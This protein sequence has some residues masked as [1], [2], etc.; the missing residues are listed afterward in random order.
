MFRKYC[1]LLQTTR[2]NLTF[3]FNSAINLSSEVW[4]SERNQ[5][6]EYIPHSDRW[7]ACDGVPMLTMWNYPLRKKAPLNAVQLVTLSR[8]RN[9]LN[10]IL[11]TFGRR[12]RTAP[13]QVTKSHV[14]KM[15]FFVGLSERKCKKMQVFSDTVTHTENKVISLYTRKAAVSDNLLTWLLYECS[16]RQSERRRLLLLSEVTP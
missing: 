9:S 15:L 5:A 1:L 2:Q 10:C 7:Q 4:K 3:N 16:G 12:D 13:E 14:L 6:G 8:G 11:W